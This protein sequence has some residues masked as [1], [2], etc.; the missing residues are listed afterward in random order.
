MGMA[1]LLRVLIMSCYFLDYVETYRGIIPI[2][3]IFARD[4]VVSQKAFEYA[5]KQ[6][7]RRFKEPFFE[8]NVTVDKININDNFQLASAICR[9]MS[10]GVFAIIGQKTTQSSDIV[11]AFTSTFHMPYLTPSLSRD[12]S[13][14]H[15]MFEIHLKP[16]FTEALIELIRFL[17]WDHVHFLYDSDEGLIRL[18]RIFRSMRNA[19][20][21]WFS[22][23]RFNDIN[24]VHD[25]L[26]QIDRGDINATKSFVL[27]LSSE[28]AYKTVLKQIPEV[29]MNKYGYNYLLGTLDFKSLNLSRYR[30]GGVNITGFQLIDEETTDNR[31]FIKE[32]KKLHVTVS[33]F[34]GTNVVPSSAALTVDAVT[35]LEDTI[36]AMLGNNSDAFRYT[37]RRKHVYNYNRTRGV[38]CTTDPPTPWMHGDAIYALL[39]SRNPPGISGR[40]HFDEKGF[41][42]DYKLGV[43]TVNLESGP[44]KLGTWSSGIG[45]RSMHAPRGKYNYRPP[46]TGNT[47]K[48]VTSIISK[49]FLMKKPVE[50]GVPPVGNDRYEGYAVDLSRHIARLLGFDY[51]IKLVEDG[52]YGTKIAPNKWN[53]MIGELMIECCLS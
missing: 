2:G 18:Q 32:M 49:P 33:S 22:V 28:E 6:H 30:H 7:K 46:G 10:E 20:V 31:D 21:D 16:D 29:G 9:Q 24:H 35:S 1:L 37:F 42:Q 39:K 44:N 3:G 38:P 48:I 14:K 23:K 19:S 27:D 47:T 11:Q 8:F 36:A 51:I 50:N 25:D 43:Y 34:D 52:A 45:F 4:D 26:R 13:R 5:I 12:T 15:S 41:R 17:Q 53:G 40:L